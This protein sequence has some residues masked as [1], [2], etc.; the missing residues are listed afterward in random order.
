MDNHY[1]N[2][3]LHRLLLLMKV[4]PNCSYFLTQHLYLP[5]VVSPMFTPS[6][7]TRHQQQ[8][9]RPSKLSSLISPHHLNTQH[10]QPNKHHLA[11]V[12][13]SSSHQATSPHKDTAPVTPDTNGSTDST[14]KA[15]LSIPSSDQF[16][17]DSLERSMKRTAVQSPP[18][19]NPG[20]VSPQDNAMV[21]YA[22]RDG[23]A[24]LSPIWN[25]LQYLRCESS[26]SGKQ[27][28]RKLFF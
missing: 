16:E 6:P 1:I 23:S 5:S 11:I 10:H 26:S 4:P 22:V 17:V 7:P 18:Q 13:E 2:N 8:R 14:L 9:Q 28:K 25:Q 3:S 20:L 24:P 15:S 21:N 12:K 27:K 19:H